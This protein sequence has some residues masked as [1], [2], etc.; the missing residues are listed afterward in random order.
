MNKPAYG[1]VLFYSTSGAV[2][3]EN[4]LQGEGFEVKLIPIPRHLS[5][6]CGVALR[7]EWPLMEEVSSLLE[8]VRVEYDSLH[9]I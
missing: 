4:V 8:A 9:H 1:V 7:F 6:D 3:A 5:S 2:R